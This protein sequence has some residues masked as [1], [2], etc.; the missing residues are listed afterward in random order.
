MNKI[1]NETTKVEH[2]WCGSNDRWI[3]IEYNEQRKIVGLNFM[4]GD[5]YE[6]FKAWCHNDRALMSFY[7]AMSY[8][9]PIEKASCNTLEFIN[10]VMWAFHEAVEVIGMNLTNK[11]K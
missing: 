4:Q 1:K 3:Y 10:K 8:T 9:F 7:I 5:E 6:S 2:V 11:T